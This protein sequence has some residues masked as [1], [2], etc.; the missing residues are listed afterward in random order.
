MNEAGFISQFKEIQLSR[1]YAAS[2]VR[3]EVLLL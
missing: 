1:L 3:P 2:A